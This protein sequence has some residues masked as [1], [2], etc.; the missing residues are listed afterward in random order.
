M[1]TVTEWLMIEDADKF[2][3]V[4]EDRGFSFYR[5]G[6]ESGICSR[7]TLRRAYEEKRI[8]KEIAYKICG[9]FGMDDVS[10]L[11]GHKT[12]FET[13][14]ELK[15]KFEE[16]ARS[17]YGYSPER[18]LKKLKAKKKGKKDGKKKKKDCKSKKKR[19]K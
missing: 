1:S 6:K 4:F 13:S 10:E 15:H 19:K 18:K 7:S 9:Y 11:I 16:F 8:S 2:K 14:E 5:F 12:Y 17:I 3:K